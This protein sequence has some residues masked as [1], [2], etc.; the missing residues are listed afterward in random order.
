MKDRCFRWENEDGS[1]TISRHLDEDASVNGYID[2]YF[3]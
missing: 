1:G 3:G 2:Q